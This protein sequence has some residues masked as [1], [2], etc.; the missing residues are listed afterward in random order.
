MSRR[1]D[2]PTVRVQVYFENP[3]IETALRREARAAKIPLSRAAERAI[4]RGLLKRPT[5]DPEDR[6]LDLERSLRDHM[7]STARDMAILQELVVELARLILLRL[8]D[9]P[10]DEDALLQAAADSRIERL[11][12]AAAARIA[13]GG[14]GPTHEVNGHATPEDR[15]FRAAAT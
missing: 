5:A 10:A 13:T 7:R 8:P 15:S 6:L 2:H 3:R 9:T 4:E 12:D 14:P 11:L 1:E